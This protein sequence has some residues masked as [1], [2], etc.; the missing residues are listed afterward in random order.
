[1]KA[2]AIFFLFYHKLKFPFDKFKYSGIIIPERRRKMYLVQIS[3][4]A[5][6]A[7]H[8]M[9]LLIQNR[10]SLLTVKDMT[11]ECEASEAHLAKV[12]QKLAKSGLVTAIRGPQ[13]GYTLTEKGEEATILTI[14]E[15]VEGAI[16]PR[17]C[18]L[19]NKICI[20]SACIF[21]GVI[22]KAERE[23]KDYFAS[24]KLKDLVR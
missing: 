22:E 7:I 24:K 12:M 5:S 18:L 14:Y 3:E 11:Q 19:K 8:S 23:I 16:V 6:L 15:A 10:G 17:R 1:L 20:F 2:E 13:G 21:G 9:A 4:A